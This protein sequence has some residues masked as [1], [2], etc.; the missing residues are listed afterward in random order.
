MKCKRRGGVVYFFRAEPSGEIKIGCSV[1]PA[2]RIR[3]LEQRRDDTV[4]LLDAIRCNT[5]GEALALERRLQEINAD[6]RIGKTDWFRMSEENL[7]KTIE[8]AYRGEIT[9]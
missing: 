7:Q 9:L 2:R 3:Q 4:H 6:T 8:L 5:R 1:N